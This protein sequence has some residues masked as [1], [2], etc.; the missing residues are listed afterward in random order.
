MLTKEQEKKIVKLLIQNGEIDLGFARL[1]LKK[2]NGGRGR[3]HS[4]PFKRGVF[5]RL[6]AVMSNNLKKLLK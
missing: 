1:E 6:G 3:S 2:V 4:T 5:Y